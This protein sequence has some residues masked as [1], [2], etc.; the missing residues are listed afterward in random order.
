MSALDRFD[1]QE[2]A[3]DDDSFAAAGSC[4]DFAA[5]HLGESSQLVA[6]QGGSSALGKVYVDIKFIVPSLAW[7]TG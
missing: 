2:V 1:V 3:P 5:R 6:V 4:Q 7:V